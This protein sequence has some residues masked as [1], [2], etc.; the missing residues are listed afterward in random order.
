M[1]PR[2]YVILDREAAQ[3]G[4]AGNLVDATRAAADAGARFF[5]LREKN[6]SSGEYWQLAEDV[7][8]TLAAYDGAILVVNDRADIALAVSARGVHRPQNGLPVKT[9]RQLLEHRLIGVSCHDRAE[10]EEAIE[11]G[12]DFVTLSPVFSTSS[13]PNV[14]PLGIPTVREVTTAVPVPVYVL[15]G[16]TPA[17]IS[18]CIGAGA[19]GVAVLSGIMEAKDPYAATDDYLGAI[20][21]AVGFDLP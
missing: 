7:A 21:E 2:L 15:G 19:H 20:E 6:V 8:Q 18:H 5:Q 10:L 3:R 13:K 14:E 16:V 1:L 4:G 11:T 12:A 9:L 17:R